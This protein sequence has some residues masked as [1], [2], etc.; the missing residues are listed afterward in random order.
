MLLRA[1]PLS[2]FGRKVRMAISHLGLWDRI[3]MVKADPMDP[4]D[5]LRHDNPLGKIPTLVTDDGT[6]VFDSRVI[7]EYLDHVAGGGRIIPAS[8]RRGSRRLRCRRCGDGVMDAAILIVYEAR[9][10]P[11]ELHH[12]PWLDYQRGK[13]VRG[14]AA[15]AKQQ[16]D[17]ARFDVGTI[18]AACMLGYL[19][20]RKQVDWRPEFPALVGWL[21]GFRANIPSLT[22]PLP[23]REN[24]AAEMSTPTTLSAHGAEIPVIG[25]G[26]SGLGKGAAEL[27]A[28]ALRLGYRH[29]DAAG[30]IRHRARRRRRHPR[31]GRAA[32]GDLPHHQGFRREPGRP[33]DFARSVETSL[34][35]LQ[36]DYVDLLLIHWPNPQIPMTD[37]MGTL[38]AAR[39]EGLT[40]HISVLPTSPSN[41]WKRR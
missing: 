16:V 11:A 6:A 12:Q 41:C 33:A 5:V 1:T 23:P 20:V 19:D 18:T 39:R 34:G 27:V 35:E 8:G 38:A 30:K 26:T 28:I 21:D 15:F 7:L 25:F 40:R 3:E 32:R 24:E 2:P 13:V 9:H 4:A 22:Q 14:L 29:I 31:L 17:P 10:R 37:L 36:V